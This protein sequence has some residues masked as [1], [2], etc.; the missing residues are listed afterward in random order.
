M[1]IDFAS[2]AHGSDGAADYTGPTQTHEYEYDS[3]LIPVPVAGPLD[4]DDNPVTR[5][6]KVHSGFGVRRVRWAVGRSNRPP[7]IPAMKDELTNDRLIS[8][9]VAPELPQPDVQR[10][11]WIFSVQGVYEYVQTVPRIAGKHTLP[12]G[13]YPYQVNPNQ[14]IAAAVAGGISGL[15]G[16]TD[17]STGIEV[18]GGALVNHQSD[19]YFWPFTAIPAQCS[20]DDAFNS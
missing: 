10:G 13:R 9:V 12:T 14:S 11:G 7:I 5:I 1:A 8:A 15:T 4:G 3:G 20:T 17:F 19:D 6:V 16:V 18:A 2:R